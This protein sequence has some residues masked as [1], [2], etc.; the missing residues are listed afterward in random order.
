MRADVTEMAIEILADSEHTL[1]TDAVRWRTFAL[2]VL[3][4]FS[5]LVGQHDKLKADHER[6]QDEYFHLLHST[7]GLIREEHESLCRKHSNVL[8]SAANTSHTRSIQ[9]RLT[10]RK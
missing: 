5:T 3:A 1:A 7:K 6:V 10:N 9:G 4:Q 2:D 8:K